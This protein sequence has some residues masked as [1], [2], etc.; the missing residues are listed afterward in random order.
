MANLFARIGA[1]LKA[2][3]GKTRKRTGE[4]LFASLSSFGGMFGLPGSWGHDKLEQARHYRLWTYVAVRAIAEQIAQ[5]PPCVA[6]RRTPEQ[7]AEAYANKKAWR[8]VRRDGG[9]KKAITSSVQEHEELENVDSDHPLF[10]LFHDPN[11]PDTA[12]TF[13]FR[14]IL[15]LELTGECYWLK[16]RNG[17]GLP[18][19]LWPVFPHWVQP[20]RGGANSG[21]LIDA[22]TIRPMGGG[23]S[24]IRPIQVDA[25]DMVAIRYPSPL[26][27]VH[28]WSPLA[29]NA[30]WVDAAE[31]I[32]SDRWYSFE[33]GM[34]PG[35]VIKLDPNIYGRQG[36]T[37]EQ[38][39][40]MYA[41]LDERLRGKEKAGRPIMLSPGMEPTQT[42]R[43]P[44][45]MAYVDS[46][47]QMRDW[48]LA[49]H[50][51]SKTVAGLSDDVNRAS[52][53]AS[54]ANFI[55][56]TCAPKYTLIG[57]VATEELAR[58]FADDLVVYWPSE[59]PDDPEQVNADIQVDLAA[60]AITPNEIRTKRGREPYEFG[61]DDPVMPQTVS[62][63][64]WGTGEQAPGDEM[65]EE[66]SRD[67][68]EAE[69]EATKPEPQPSA[70]GN[71]KAYANGSWDY[72]SGTPNRIAA[73]AERKA[74][75]QLV[76]ERMAAG[77]QVN[78]GDTIVHVPEQ[79][80]PHVTVA[81]PEPDQT[82]VKELA[83]EYHRHN[84][85]YRQSLELRTKAADEERLR[86]EELV[87]EHRK[88]REASDR[89]AER[90]AA[91]VEALAAKEFVTNVTVPEQPV[92]VRVPEQPP[93][94]VVVNLPEPKP[95][96]NFKVVPR[97]GPDGLAVEYE[98]VEVG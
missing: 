68:M 91:A 33:G 49:I 60:G 20:V 15:F 39:L 21:R 50:R 57:Q 88:S 6:I 27:L 81:V 58:E 51:V 25:D 97:R 82:A 83:A 30:E 96:K 52:M 70:N 31:A 95:A 14:T 42:T 67:R 16:I 74:V 35:F 23:E 8:Y 24:G 94:A 13:W 98:R 87:A 28:G 92:T 9:R 78:Q 4:A 10:R 69:A 19:E 55:T 46:S 93:A 29:A 44:V 40:G 12:Y 90:L 80:A 77:V 75:E 22:Y 61:G 36:P 1:W 84:E 85:Q 89:L 71:G 72:W 38:R 3:A 32:D 5:H 63:V 66:L 53:A 45:E 86:H 56:G 7:A 47:A 54:L 41:D 73:Y 64:P 34:W 79:P 2:A 76:E 26:S 37:R 62:V 65:A 43:T 48:V 17:L 18:V 11:R 59:A